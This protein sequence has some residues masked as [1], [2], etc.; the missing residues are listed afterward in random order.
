VKTAA[1]SRQRRLKLQ[2]SYGQAMIHARGYSAPEAAA[3][4]L[5][6]GALILRRSPGPQLSVSTPQEGGH[7]RMLLGRNLSPSRPPADVF[8][9]T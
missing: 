9:F 6:E 5:E 1:A 4:L 2:T 8:A 3:A 7:V